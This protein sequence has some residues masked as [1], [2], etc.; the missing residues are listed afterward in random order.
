M[1][2][3]LPVIVFIFGIMQIDWI[4]WSDNLLR[5]AADAA[6]RCGGVNS[7]TE[8]CGC[9]DLISTG[10]QVFAP[11]NGATLTNSSSCAGDGDKGLVGTHE[12]DNPIRRQSHA[13]SQILLPNG[14]VM[15]AV[16]FF[17]LCTELQADGVSI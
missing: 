13:E 15:R 11:V 10:N 12:C 17:C 16:Y 5:A 4:V 3:T 14:L 7:A 2:V 6:T 9:T 8:P 1:L